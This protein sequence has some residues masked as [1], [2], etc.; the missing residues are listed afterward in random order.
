MALAPIIMIHGAFCGGWTFDT[1]R[2][3]FEAAGHAVLAPDLPGHEPGGLVAGQSV[4]DYAGAVAK[5][6]GE[7]ATPPILIGHS[8][9]GLVA[10][11]AADRVPVAGLVLLAPSSPWGVPGQSIEEGVSAVSLFALGPYWLQAVA[12]DRS[13]T[14]QCSHDRLPAA[15]QAALFARMGP[16]SG[17][18]LFEVLNWWLDPTMATSVKDVGGAP[19][20]TVA[21]GR[22][23]INPAPTVRKT[24]QRLGGDYRVFDT[25]SHWLPGEPG[26]DEV[27]QA[28]YDWISALPSTPAG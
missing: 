25:M 3:P 21:G 24:A 26:W 17:R 14:A 16:E 28:A 27:A 13:I 18:A 12:P 19:V 15:T 1:F 6:A 2:K 11:M 23:V 22:D 8:M 9:G 20:L 4:I 5:L 10:Q 7:Q